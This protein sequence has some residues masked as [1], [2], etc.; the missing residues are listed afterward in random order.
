M[1]RIFTLVTLIFLITIVTA[2]GNTPEWKKFFKISEIHYEDDYAVAKIKNTTN[3][4]YVVNVELEFKSGD[5]TESRSEELELEAYSVEDL[6]VFNSE[7]DETYKI[8]VK[9]I[10]FTE[11]L[12]LTNKTKITLEELHYGYFN[13]YEKHLRNKFDVM[14]PNNSIE[15]KMSDENIVIIDD[16]ITI[17]AYSSDK[18]LNI[19]ESYDINNGNLTLLNIEANNQEYNEIL[20]QIATHIVS[21]ILL[22]DK[23][24]LPNGWYLKLYDILENNS[25]DY[26]ENYLIYKRLNEN[27][28]IS[29]TI[30]NTLYLN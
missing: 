28:Q 5:I 22:D 4:D 16:E 9:N 6:R 21:S 26:I 8:T 2:C 17:G 18:T 25:E 29:I 14:Y 7:A 10:K 11:V 3:K 15:I 27:N 1:K 12:D 19:L 30:A 24:D 23:N 20:N 13:I